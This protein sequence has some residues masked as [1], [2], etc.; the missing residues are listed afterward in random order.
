MKKDLFI[1]LIAI[2]AVA[3]VAFALDRV[4]PD[5]PL[6]PSQPYAAK[7]ETAREPKSGKIVMHV[8]GEAV[9]EEEFNAFA[10]NLPE[11]QRGMVNNPQ[12]K[13]VL[14]NEIA[15]LKVLEQ[16]A[17][18]QGM[19]NDPEVRSQIEMTNAQI[20]AMRALQKMVEPRVE[21]I[22]REEFDKEK[23]DTIELKHIAVAYA[24]GQ[25]PSRDGSSR[26]VPQA[27][28]KA[29]AIATRLRGGANF[30]ELAR[31]ESDDPN[32]APNGG[33]LGP[34]RREMLPPEI[35]AMLAKLQPGQISEPV[36]TPLGI[37]VFRY[38]PISLETLRPQLQQRARQQAMQ[39]AV[40]KLEKQAKIALEPSFFPPA[41]EAP[42]GTLPGTH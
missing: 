24:G 42:R 15:K 38:D 35:A 11:E 34:A 27:I 10:Q 12:G 6:T 5:L 16:E 7:G 26:A 33:S 37:H 31:A 20:V 3:A 23:N 17:Q 29:K 36:R 21:Q 22:I 30:A 39:E 32:S 2:L 8:N 14:A 25:Y 19:A 18:R 41:P 40:T 13:R 9:T 28:E 1:A 4:R